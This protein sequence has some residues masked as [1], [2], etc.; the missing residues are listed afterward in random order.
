MNDRNKLFATS[1]HLQPS[2]IFEGTA[3]AYPSEEPLM[4]YQEGSWLRFDLAG[5]PARNIHNKLECL[6]LAGI[7]KLV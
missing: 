3:G 5:R 4:C 7:S 2:V 6:S 1:R